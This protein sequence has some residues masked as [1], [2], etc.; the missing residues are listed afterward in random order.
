LGQSKDHGWPIRLSG[1]AEF[2]AL[3]ALA[4]F[5]NKETAL[6]D[7]LQDEIYQLAGR[8]VVLSGSLVCFGHA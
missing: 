7:H 5:G 6:L 3:L 1:L 8:R 2:L 4:L